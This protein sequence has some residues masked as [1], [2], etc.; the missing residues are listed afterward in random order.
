LLDHYRQDAVTPR[1]YFD[2]LQTYVKSQHLKLSDGRVIPWVDEDLD[3]FTG[4]WLARDLKIEKHT[5]YGRGDHYNHSSF[6]DL[7][8]TGL[9]GLRPRADDTVE[10]RPLLPPGAWEWFCLDAVPYHG[11]LLTILWDRTGEH[12]HK[13]AGLRL[14]ADGRQIAASTTMYLLK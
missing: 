1:D 12:F 10:V 14:F 5:F 11:R 2:A 3:P 13:G 4:N 9:I 8:I 7:V 6:A